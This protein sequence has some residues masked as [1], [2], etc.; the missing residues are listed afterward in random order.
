MATEL[1]GT[2]QL[3]TPCIPG[4]TLLKVAALAL[5]LDGHDLMTAESQS[6][7][8][9]TWGLEPN[10]V[11]GRMRRR[12]LSRPRP[13]SRLTQNKEL[14]G[15]CRCHPYIYILPESD[16]SLASSFVDNI[17]SG[18]NAF[19]NST[20]QKS[21]PSLQVSGHSSFEHRLHFAFMLLTELDYTRSHA[22]NSTLPTA[23]HT[24]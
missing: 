10:K 5:F 21:E 20:N 1:G 23:L 19:P 15:P 17:F 7:Q 9:S 18:W 12:Q 11:E 2:A 24:R 14:R 22:I 13:G 6:C 4:R 3:V 16:R 8:H